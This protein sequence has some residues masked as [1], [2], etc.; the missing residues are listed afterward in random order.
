MST[1]VKH[2]KYAVYEK[3]VLPFLVIMLFDQANST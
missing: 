2:I 1:L 3:L